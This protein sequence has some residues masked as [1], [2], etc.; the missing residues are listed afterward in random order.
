MEVPMFAE[1]TIIDNRAVS[2][3]E[4]ARLLAEAG[5]ELDPAEVAALVETLRREQP[6]GSRSYFARCE[7]G[8]YMATRRPGS[9][10]PDAE[11]V[12]RAVAGLH[13]AYG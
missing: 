4:A 10:R 9:N 12:R 13:R 6:P 2:A 1:I 3:D 7:H 11:G 8:A 5:D